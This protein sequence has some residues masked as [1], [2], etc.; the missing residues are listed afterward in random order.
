MMEVQEDLVQDGGLVL[1]LVVDLEVVL[2]PSRADA[3]AVS[4]AVQMASAL[5]PLPS[6]PEP[7]TEA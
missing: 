7:L 2:A 3:E 4:S 6:E 1:A 5:R